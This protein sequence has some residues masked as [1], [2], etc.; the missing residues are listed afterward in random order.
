MTDSSDRRSWLSSPKA[1]PQAHLR[2]FCFPYAGGGAPIFRSWPEHLR[3]DIEVC[4]VHL[5]GR[6]SRL[7]EPPFTRLTALVETLALVLSPHLAKPFAFF[8]HSMGALIGFELVRELRQNGGP[9]PVHLFVSGR[10]APHL[11]STEPPIHSLRGPKFVEALR[12]YNGTPQEVFE[13]P[14][15]MA[16]LIPAL[17]ADFAICE[18]YTYNNGAPIDC[19]ISAFGGLEDQTVGYERLAAW[20]EVSSASF[21]VHMF[22]GDHFFLHSAEPL[23]IKTLTRMLRGYCG[24][25]S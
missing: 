17:R 23:L 5:P 11:P 24:S 21:S 20:R 9:C 19:S 16:L 10:G 7:T 12:R 22:P 6:G 25:H 14:E 8:G 18:T 15:L 4:A 1:N 3:A 2:L 13:Y